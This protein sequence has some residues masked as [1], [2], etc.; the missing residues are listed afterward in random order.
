MTTEELRAAIGARDYGDDAGFRVLLEQIMTGLGLD[1]S[2]VTKRLG[3]SKPAVREMA[4]GN[5]SLPH[6][7]LQP[8][9]LEDLLLEDLP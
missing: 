3:C 6:P 8:G 9:V 1:I 7:A 4:A 2:E 5:G